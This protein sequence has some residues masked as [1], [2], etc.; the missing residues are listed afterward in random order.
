VFGVA[1]AFLGL[2]L[3]FTGAGR[4]T[5]KMEVHPDKVVWWWSFAKHEHPIGNLTEATL[6]EPGAP[7]S[8]GEWSGFIGGGFAAVFA[9]WLLSL[10]YS[11]FKAEPTLG[12]RTLMIVPHF[13][14][15]LRIWPIGTFATGLGSPQ[16]FAAQQAIQQA[17]DVFH[18]HT[19]A[20]E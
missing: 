20:G 12:S 4:V 2:L 16:A 15:P 19:K 10:A 5:A 3:V 8:G 1:I 9:W 6:V 7:R 14:A 11:G 18:S 17:I 13:G